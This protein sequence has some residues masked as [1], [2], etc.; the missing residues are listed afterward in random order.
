MERPVL[1]AGHP[2]AQASQPLPGGQE[3]Q[4][5]TGT[6]YTA[7]LIDL[8]RGEGP[9]LLPGCGSDHTGAGAGLQTLPEGK[10]A[11]LQDSTSYV[12]SLLLYCN[13]I[14]VMCFQGKI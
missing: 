4:V 13:S 1:P 12:S 5:A 14:F 3:V 8:Q 9:G 6:V 10:H 7:A 11:G 2:G